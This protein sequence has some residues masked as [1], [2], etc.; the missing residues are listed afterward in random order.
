MNYKKI[1]FIGLGGACQ[2]H[3]RIFHDLLPSTTKFYA[4][5]TKQ[6]T[7]HLN[8]DF[9]V[10]RNSTLTAKYSLSV[11]T[12]YNFHKE[13]NIICQFPQNIIFTKS[14]I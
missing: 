10:N 3:L 12:K 6:T 8:S 4:F 7:P 9:S 1:L 5:R 11:S 13:Q 14:K 2:R